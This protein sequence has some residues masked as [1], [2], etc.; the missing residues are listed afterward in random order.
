[1]LIAE[2]F[3]MPTEVRQFQGQ[4]LPLEPAEQTRLGAEDG[5]GELGV[6]AVAGDRVWDVQGKI[7]VR[8]GPLRYDQFL[9]YLPDR[10]PDAGRK[11]FF[12][13]SQ[14]VRF[15]VGPE[16]DFD[17]Q[18]VLRAEDVP[19]CEL[20]DDPAAGPRLGWNCWLL[21]DRAA[22]PAEDALFDGDDDPKI[23]GVA[24]YGAAL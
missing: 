9:R 7:R 18:L 3:G 17:V 2:Y 13:L 20:T 19:A 22:E 11:A 12:L 10:T 4:W 21:T 15:Y 8:L 1:V 14:L 23:A 5:N 6:T 16:F 24:G